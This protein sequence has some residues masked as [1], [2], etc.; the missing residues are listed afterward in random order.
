MF[1]ALKAIAVSGGCR[2]LSRSP[3][4]RFIRQQDGASAVEFALVA[5]PFIALIFA[6][7]E[8]AF[9]FFAGQTLEA[10][11]ANASRLILT[12][13][14]QTQ[15]MSASAFKTRVCAQL[16]AL[17]DCANGVYVDVKTYTTF[18]SADMTSPIQNGNFDTSKLTY[19][20]G[21]PGDIVVMKL[22]YQW[23]IYATAWLP[24]ISNLNGNQRL[25]VATATFRNEPYK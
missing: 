11:A 1:D 13:Q 6:I 25:L 9:V 21:G 4:R 5:L 2:L 15:G 7:L 14:A 19:A 17:V 24:G 18:A 10:V 20:P 8:T 23:P 16:L 3:L 12:G 22:Y